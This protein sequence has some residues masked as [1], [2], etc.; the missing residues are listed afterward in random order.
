MPGLHKNSGVHTL[1]AKNLGCAFLCASAAAAPVAGGGY[2]SCAAHT[3]HMQLEAH[4]VLARF[5]SVDRKKLL[6]AIRPAKLKVH[7]RGSEYVL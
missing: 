2:S 1:P 5:L 7:P 3:Y 4:R 6:R